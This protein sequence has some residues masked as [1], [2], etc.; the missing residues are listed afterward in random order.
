LNLVDAALGVDVDE[1]VGDQVGGEP[2]SVLAV[3]AAADGFEQPHRLGDRSGHH[4]CFGHVAEGDEVRLFGQRPAAGAQGRRSSRRRRP[5][6][7]CGVQRMDQI[8]SP[9]RKGDDVVAPDVQVGRF[10]FCRNAVCRSQATTWPPLPTRWR[11]HDAID[12]APVPAS[13]QFHP[14]PTPR[15]VRCRIVPGSRAASRLPSRDR[16]S[17]QASSKT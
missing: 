9:L 17:S 13:R 5:G 6:G 1:A 14:G 2:A 15:E 16:S 8:E 3:H 7:Q 11:S 4:V 10:R 12:P